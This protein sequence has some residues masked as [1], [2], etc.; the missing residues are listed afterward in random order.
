MDA[1]PV[2]G[3]HKHF[4]H[5]HCILLRSNFQL[6]NNFTSCSLSSYLTL[7]LSIVC[8]PGSSGC[9]MPTENGQPFDSTSLELLIESTNTCPSSTTAYVSADLRLFSD[10]AFSIPS[11]TLAEGAA[12][13]FRGQVI[14]SEVPTHRVSLAEFR[15]YGH[16]IDFRYPG[17]V[18]YSNPFT[19][20]LVHEEASTFVLWSFTVPSSVFPQGGSYSIQAIL[21]FDYFPDVPGN[22]TLLLDNDADNLRREKSSV[23]FEVQI[24][25]AN[26]DQEEEDD[27]E[28]DEAN[29][30][31]VRFVI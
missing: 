29:T 30:A 25:R 9:A 10:S 21:L 19:D 11:I 4:H 18:N 22:G 5:M 28:D 14:S 7:P 16:G 27:R 31:A 1:R 24:V 6:H 8:E 17:T 20:V 23:E 12:A 3:I 2:F 15:I 26:G 13:Y